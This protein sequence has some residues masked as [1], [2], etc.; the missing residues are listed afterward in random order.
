ME[1]RGWTAKLSVA[2]FVT[3]V[4]GTLIVSLVLVAALQSLGIDILEPSFPP[5]LA[6]LP[7]TEA[8]IALITILFAWNRG[9][10]RGLGFKRVDAKTILMISLVALPTIFLA[11]AVA[12][13]EVALFGPDPLEEELDK[14]VVPRNDVQ[15]LTLVAISLFIVGPCE[16]LF[17]RG[18]VQRGF[19]NSYGRT[20]G[21]LAAS[22]LFGLWHSFNTL[23]AVLPTFVVGLVLGYVWQWTGGNTTASA[24]THGVYNT[25]A[26]ILSYIL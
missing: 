3:V 20:T 21:L 17:A 12:S 26:I 15:L 24:V 6:T 2:C 16:E 22:L 23:Y 18:F 19:E 10:F 4:L 5:A 7:F 9:G 13:G 8:T 25:I 1:G 11:S 14:A